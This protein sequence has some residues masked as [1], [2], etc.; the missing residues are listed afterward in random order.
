MTDERS[1]RHELFEGQMADLYFKVSHY[2]S[3]STIDFRF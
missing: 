3:P 1:N 2:L